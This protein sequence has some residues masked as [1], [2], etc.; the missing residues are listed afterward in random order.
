MNALEFSILRSVMANLRRVRIHIMRGDLGHGFLLFA[1]AKHESAFGTG[2][3]ANEPGDDAPSWERVR[4]CVDR[5]EADLLRAISRATIVP[6][7]ADPA[8][9]S[10]AIAEGISVLRTRDGADITEE[11]E[12]ERGR[13]I[14]AVVTGLWDVFEPAPS[15]PG[16]AGGKRPTVSPTSAART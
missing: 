12:V 16:S 3:L 8:E 15:W 1:S 14:S 6:R 10:A 11:Q 5:V 13:H 7:R 9:V 2:L 4:S